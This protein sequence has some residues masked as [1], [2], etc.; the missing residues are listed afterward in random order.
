MKVCLEPGCW[1]PTPD[2][3]CAEHQ[4][5]WRKRVKDPVYA[6]PAHRGVVR[7]DR[8]ACCGSV[9]DLCRDHMVTGYQTLCR[10]C[11]GSKG[12]KVMVDERCP[13]HG[14]RERHG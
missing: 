5:A 11:N 13:M 4:R 6:T 9:E 2:T 1:Q 7:D 8:C 3:R 12:G 14:G 10:S